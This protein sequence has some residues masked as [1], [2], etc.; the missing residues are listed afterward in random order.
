[1]F[2]QYPYINGNDLNLDYILKKVKQLLKAV[3]DLE[4]WR[5]QHEREYRQLFEWYLSLISG[6]FTP[7][8]IAAI[9]K[10]CYENL[11]DL[12]GQLVH[13]VLFGITDDGYFIAYIPES[14][15]D[16]IF[17]T[18]GLDEIIPGYDYGR[19]VLSFNIP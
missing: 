13:L 18:T 10:W 3:A 9:N 8:M 2:N 5:A 1:M 4:G 16:I 15:N 7:E 11:P 14:W 12:V 17:T 6:N 19:L